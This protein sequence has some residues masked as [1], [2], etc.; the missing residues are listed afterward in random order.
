MKARQVAARRQQCSRGTAV[1]CASM[2]G[3]WNRKRHGAV[4]CND[5]GVAFRQGLR[6]LVVA[7]LTGLSLPRRSACLMMA[8]APWARRWAA[9]RSL[10]ASSGPMTAASS[11]N[12]AISALSYSSCPQEP[13]FFPT[14]RLRR[15][16]D[17]D[18]AL[19]PTWL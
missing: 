18:V 2:A 13:L 9:R 12:D 8:P 10:A 14:C 11:W 16:R 6:T 7:F 19:E 3:G 4:S 1:T 17:D 15:A 5:G